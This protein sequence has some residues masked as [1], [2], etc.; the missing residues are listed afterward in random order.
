[1]KSSKKVAK[2][3]L[4]K[5]MLFFLSILFLFVA[6]KIYGQLDRA[7]FIRDRHQA[8]LD[9]LNKQYQSIHRERLKYEEAIEKLKKDDY[10]ELVARKQLRMIKPGEKSYIVVFKDSENEPE[11]DSS[12]LEL[13]TTK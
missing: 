11:K 6:I 2:R 8:E 9:E 10:I 7:L 4:E 13:L 1:M 3:I 12:L 5:L